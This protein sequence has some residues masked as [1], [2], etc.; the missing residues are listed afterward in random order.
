MI[1]NKILKDEE[2]SE[3]YHEIVASCGFSEEQDE[4]AR[5]LLRDII[6]KREKYSLENTLHSLE[7]TI[8]KYHHILIVGGGPDAVQILKWIKNLTNPPYIN[9]KKLLVVAIDGAAELLHHL[10]ISP[11]II[12]TDLDGLTLKTA[13]TMMKYR[14]MY[15]IVHAHGDN[16][17]RINEFHSVLHSTNQLIG[18]TQSKTKFP[19]INAGGFTDGDR[20]LYFLQNFLKAYHYLILVGF[21]FGSTIGKFSKPEL[22][23]NIHASELKRKKLEFGAQIIKNLCKKMESEVIFIEYLHK[24]IFKSELEQK[25]KCTF[26]TVTLAEQVKNLI[27]HDLLYLK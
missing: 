16:R 23:N 9:T 15:L 8:Q 22:Q 17:H 13:K 10:H 5:D 3:I 2:F 20:A 14:D 25:R 21:D 1:L 18:T 11:H 7:A 27:P 6:V 12:F 26:F 24:F 19:I 4:K